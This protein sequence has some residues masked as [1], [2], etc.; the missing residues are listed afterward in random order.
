MGKKKNR[1]KREENKKMTLEEIMRFLE[2]NNVEYYEYDKSVGICACQ[3]GDNFYDY[4]ERPQAVVFDE[5]FKFLK[6]NPKV[7]ILECCDCCGCAGW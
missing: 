3:I 5:K 1:I 6:D 4:G 2:D 7:I